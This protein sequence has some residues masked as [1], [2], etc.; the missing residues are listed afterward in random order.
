MSLL[1][2]PLSLSISPLPFSVPIPLFLGLCMLLKPPVS[3]KIE[4][5]DMATFFCK[6][7]RKLFYPHRAEWFL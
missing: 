2:S 4:K 3:I 6:N 5:C 1:L 7:G